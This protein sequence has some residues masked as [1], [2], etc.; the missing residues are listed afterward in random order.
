MTYQP[1]TSA[2]I[3]AVALIAAGCEIPLTGSNDS[4]VTVAASSNQ[5]PTPVEV[6]ISANPNEADQYLEVN[7]Y[8][9][10]GQNGDYETT[11]PLEAEKAVAAG[12]DVR[13]V[14]R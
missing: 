3:L 8:I 2:A 10:G 6:N 5:P 7:V 9:I 12:M 11:D 4:A 13:C 14:Q 1:Y